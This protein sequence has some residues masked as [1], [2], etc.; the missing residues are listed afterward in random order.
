MFKKTIKHLSYFYRIFIKKKTPLFYSIIFSLI[1]LFFF[2]LCFF[3]LFYTPGHTTYLGCC[4]S[5]IFEFQV[6]DNQ[7]HQMGFEHWLP[8]KSQVVSL[9]SLLAVSQLRVMLYLQWPGHACRCC[10]IFKKGVTFCS[11]S[12][13]W[14]T[15]WPHGQQTGKVWFC[16]FLVYTHTDLIHSPIH[17]LHYWHAYIVLMY[18]NY[19]E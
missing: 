7:Q 17:I 4:K 8:T 6:S 10:S 19:V 13:G 16:S 14:T 12:G 1:N 15:G 5:E 2:P 18:I 9:L 11:A 3:F